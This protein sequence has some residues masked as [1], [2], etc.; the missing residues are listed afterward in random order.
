MHCPCHTSQEK[1]EPTRGCCEKCE[2]GAPSKEYGFE[3]WCKNHD[4]DCHSQ[5]KPAENW[6]KEFNK[7]LLN[8]WVNQIDYDD[9]QKMKSYIRSLLSA[10][11]QSI[12]ESLEASVNSWITV[13][14]DG[15]EIID[16]VRAMK[17]HVLTFIRGLK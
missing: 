8:E 17:D 13:T 16:D 15:K 3:F 10:Q 11:K 1:P 7:K 4:C 9:I 2:D 6:E 14:K 5:E 12:V